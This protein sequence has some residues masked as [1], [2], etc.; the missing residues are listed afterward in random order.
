VTFTALA[1]GY[2][3]SSEGQELQIN[4]ELAVEQALTEASLR[5]LLCAR[6]ASGWRRMIFPG[7]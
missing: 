6:I 1:A 2:Q 7:W 4:K 5:R 3:S